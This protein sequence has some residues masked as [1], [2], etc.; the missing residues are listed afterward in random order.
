MDSKLSVS[1]IFFIFTWVIWYYIRTY[2][3]P[4]FMSEYYIISMCFPDIF[5]FIGSA[6]GLYILYILWSLSSEPSE[7]K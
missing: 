3:G 7:D 1:V 4:M 6:V 5:F 2:L